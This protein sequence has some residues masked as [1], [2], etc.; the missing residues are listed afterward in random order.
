MTFIHVLCYATM[1]SLFMYLARIG[2]VSCFI[3]LTICEFKGK[4]VWA[5][6]LQ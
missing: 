5:I 3:L 1:L 4:N 2:S 6:G